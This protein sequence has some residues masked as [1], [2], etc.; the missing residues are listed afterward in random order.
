MKAQVDADACIGCELC[1]ETCPE[2]FEM[3][4][5]IAVVKVDEVPADAEDSAKEAEDLCPVDAITV[6]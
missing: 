6:E 5:D 3:D 1:P 4:G 2:V